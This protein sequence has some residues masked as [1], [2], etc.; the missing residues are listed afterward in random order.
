MCGDGDGIVMDE[1]TRL[2][3]AGAEIHILEPEGMET[4]VETAQPLPNNSGKHQEGAGRLFDKGW[5]HRVQS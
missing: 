2:P 3:E 1:K 5:S 4:L